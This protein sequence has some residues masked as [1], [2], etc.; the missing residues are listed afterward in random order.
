MEAQKDPNALQENQI[1][2]SPETEAR[3]ED[4]SLDLQNLEIDEGEVLKEI[5]L[6]NR[7]EQFMNENEYQSLFED[8]INVKKSNIK[9]VYAN[10]LYF[11]KKII[12]FY[13]KETFLEPYFLYLKSTPNQTKEKKEKYISFEA[14]NIKDNKEACLS[15]DLTKKKFNVMIKPDNK[16]FT[17]FFNVENNNI[18][19]PISNF[20]KGKNEVTINSSSKKL[21]FKGAVKIKNLNS[22]EQGKKKKENSFNN[23]SSGDKNIHNES[24]TNSSQLSNNSSKKVKENS[25]N[26]NS[27]GDK[28]IHNESNTNSSQL[29]NSSSKKGDKSSEF[30]SKENTLISYDGK[31]ND[32][33]NIIIKENNDNLLLEFNKEKIGGEKFESIANKTFELMCNISLNRDIKVKTFT[34]K[35][36]DKINSFFNLNDENQINVFQ[37]DTYIPKISGKEIKKI[38]ERFP[39]NFLFFEELKIND[40][41]NYEI[42]GEV[43]QNIVNNAKQKIAQEF[44]YIHL[45]NKFNNY[46]QKNDQ[47]FI[48]LCK[49]FGLNNIEK[50]F[51]LFTDGSYI[52]I[53]FLIN[54]INRNKNEI[55]NYFQQ[56]KEKK[57]IL[58]ELNNYFKENEFDLLEIDLEKFYNLCLFYNNLKSNN[59]KF[60]ICFISDV[61][62]DKLENRIEEKIKLYMN[63][64]KDIDKNLK[65]KEEK[66]SK[67]IKVYNNNVKKG[68][69]ELV[70]KKEKDSKEFILKM[71]ETI[72]KNDKLR[73]GLTLISNEIKKK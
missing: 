49:H 71:A 32:N 10:P 30:T 52:R 26:N 9:E 64:D 56:K 45:I 35:N 51:I 29:N 5:E 34:H 21:K 22:V 40:Y 69:K 6:N 17:V 8:Y 43:S 7:Y 13:N 38:Y 63:D 46:P 3:I 62:E 12:Y 15:L 37:I 20:D 72:K 28:N 1:N 25:F 24:N 47:K 60:C 44:N 33:L 14:R 54:L 55:I 4:I 65:I 68:N 27:S 11:I 36:P 61:I 58:T 53:K 57:E 16:T 2:F 23:N 18:N 50:I 48:A 67:E 66:D 59:I 39:N 31:N 19:I 73:E 70:T 41:T 42:I